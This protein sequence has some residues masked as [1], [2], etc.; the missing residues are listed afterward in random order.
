MS[1]VNFTTVIMKSYV[2]GLR[3]CLYP[4]INILHVLHNRKIERETSVLQPVTCK[5]FFNS[6]LQEK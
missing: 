5:F 2:G 4:K 3:N 1:I 6:S